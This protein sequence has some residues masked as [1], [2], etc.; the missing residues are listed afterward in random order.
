[1]DELNILKE[2]MATLKRSLDKEKIVND[3]L[4]RTVMKQKSSWLNTFVKVEFILLPILYLMFAGICAFFHVSQ[5]Y[6]VILL[7][8]SLMDV[9]VDMRTFRISPKVFSTHSMLE[10]RR[11]LVKQKKERFIHLCI[12][13]P[14]AIV[15][16]I[17][18]LNAIAN[19]SDPHATDH[20]INFAGVIGGLMGGVAG[21]I[22]VLVIYRK[23]QKTN[24]FIID[25]IPDDNS[26]NS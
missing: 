25:E 16:L 24:D 23:A 10:V 12:S 19:A 2:E 17:L 20:A 13:F 14:L 1:M 7:V 11:L 21:G 3:K 26:F 15:W 6:A 18:M 4:M 5:W 22:V 8:L 9:L